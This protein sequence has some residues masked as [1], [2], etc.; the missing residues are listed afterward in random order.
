MTLL[1]SSCFLFMLQCS[2]LNRNHFLFEAILLIS[3]LSCALLDWMCPGLAAL[4]LPGNFFTESS[5]AGSGSHCLISSSV[6]PATY[7]PH[8]PK[9]LLCFLWC[10]CQLQMSG[11]ISG[12]L[13]SNPGFLHIP[14]CCVTYEIRYSDR[15]I[16]L[17]ISCT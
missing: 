10:L 12:F 8:L 6:C 2:L 7:F 3:H 13:P 9:R 16:V 5:W 1:S 4:Q 11:F 14:C 15:C 17:E